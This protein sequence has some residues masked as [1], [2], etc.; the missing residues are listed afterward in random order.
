MQEDIL[1]DIRRRCRMAMNGMASASMRGLGLDYK[2]NF[3]LV[4]QQIK[5]LAGSYE[6]NVELAEALWKEGTRELKILATLL[7]PLSEFTPCVADRWVTEIPNQEIREQL[8][9]NLLQEVDFAQNIAIQWCNNS[10]QSIRTSGYWLLARLL[11]SKKA[12]NAIDINTLPCVWEDILSENLFLRNA[13]TLTLKHI[14]RQSK[15]EADAI[16][17]KLAPLKNDANPISQEAY[18][19]ISFE[20]EFFWG[21]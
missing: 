2:L 13:S 11:L 5:D 6:E 7:Y 4:I 16:L 14:G 8:C 15:S 17:N 21:E 20:F 18:N 1:R 3:G 19:S 9:A 12:K 10:D